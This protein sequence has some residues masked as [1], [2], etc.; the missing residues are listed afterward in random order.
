MAVLSGIA[1]DNTGALLASAT[2]NVFNSANNS[3]VASGTTNGSG[4][5]SVTTPTTGP[6]FVVIF[7]DSGTF[8]AS[9]SRRDLV[10]V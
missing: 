9:T 7:K 8:I 2:V 6:F 3:F 5:Y 1:R 10:A 4:A